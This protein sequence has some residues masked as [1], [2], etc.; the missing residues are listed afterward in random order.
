MKHLITKVAVFITAI[1]Y[2][3]PAFA[4][5]KAKE[6]EVDIGYNWLWTNLTN[7]DWIGTD[8]LRGLA[9]IFI[10]LALFFQFKNVQNEKG[11]KWMWPG[12]IF[13]GWLIPSVWQVFR[14]PMF[15]LV[16]M[17]AVAFGIIAW[18]KGIFKA[19]S[20]PEDQETQPASPGST[21][22]GPATTTM[23]YKICSRCGQE[24]MADKACRSCGYRPV[25]HEALR[26]LLNS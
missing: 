15:L 4:A 23:G 11:A 5:E 1:I 26:I 18:R 24:A 9:W 22:V 10:F 6:G 14:L 8:P 3:I 7:T 12:S 2:T 25:D 13:F 21:Q 17:S 20:Q 16:L 19:G